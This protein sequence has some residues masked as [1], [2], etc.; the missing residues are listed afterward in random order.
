MTDV[1]LSWESPLAPLNPLIGFSIFRDNALLT[2]VSEDQYIDEDLNIGMY[3]Y[4]IQAIY[5]SGSSAPTEPIQVEIL[6]YE[7]LS[8]L[9][10]EY[11][12]LED[13]SVYL[14]WE[15]PDIENITG[16]NVYENN[17]F[18]I[19][20][21]TTNYYSAIL[22]DGN[23]Q[24]S[25]TALYGNYE[26]EET[27]VDI[28]IV[29]NSNNAEEILK[30]ELVGAY[31]NPFNPTTTITFNLATENTENT[32]L[33]IFNAKGQKVRPFINHQLTAGIHSVEW[34]GKN[35]LD[36]SVSSGVYF[37]RLIVDNQVIE[38]KKCILIK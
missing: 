33:I 1:N 23:Y 15:N 4:S 2:T 10:L 14:S 28:N 27:S 31:P 24:F 3:N 17:E 13:D 18:L 35:E 7:I 16:F 32:E 5:M 38:T 20:S 26:S 21:D 11:E 19:T 37:Y 6:G 36:H 22:E 25:I 30:N 12:I 8:P 34:N 9:N 29:A